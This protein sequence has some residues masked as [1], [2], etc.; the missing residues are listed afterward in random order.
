MIIA[1]CFTLAVDIYYEFGPVYLTLKWQLGPAQLIWYNGVLCL[2]L[3]I[4]NGVLPTFIS[5]RVSGSTSIISGIGGF[6]LLMIGI[7]YTDSPFWMLLWFG[8]SG[9]FIGLA[10]TLLTVKISD[11][12]P[13]TIQGEVMGTQLSLRVLGD[14][15]I[16]LLGGVL[17]IVSPRL[18]LLIAVVIGMGTLL[19]YK[20]KH[21]ET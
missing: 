16:C 12:A 11:T 21:R 13:A 4:G 1:T 2:G 6:V 20:V 3:A 8:L 9:L 7:I 15:L 18:I 17:L 14:G 10:V 19:Y 5:S